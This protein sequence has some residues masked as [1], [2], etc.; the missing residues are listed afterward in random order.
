MKNIS[1]MIFELFNDVFMLPSNVATVLVSVVVVL[2]WL[3]VGLILNRV[4]AVVIVKSL[5]VTKKDARAATISKLVVNIV[6]YVVWFI[7]IL[8]I[9]EQFGVNIAP[10]IASAGVLGLAIGFGAQELVKDFITGFFI[11]FEHTF[12][13]DDVI[14]TQGFKGKVL[15]IG[16]R[17]TVLEN[18]KGEIKAVSNGNL[19][20]VTNFSK[21]NSIGIVDFGVAYDTDLKVFTKLMD[22]FIVEETKK[23][24]DFVTPPKFLGVTELADSSINVRIIFETKPMAYFELERLLRLDV[25][26]FCAKKNIE[27]PFPQVVVH[28]AE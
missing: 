28:N 12:D 24:E 21:N 25:V 7:I 1:E 9:L 26:A 3:I 23:Y 27:I 22:A 15:S 10:L 5:K 16:L 2:L 8:I 4:L 11:I 20:S 13:I 14:E 19:G 17:T 18:W 6:R